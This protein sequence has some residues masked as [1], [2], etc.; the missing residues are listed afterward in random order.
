MTT[1][2]MDED[3]KKAVQSQNEIGWNLS[4]EGLWS[5]EWGL[6]QS[7]Y[8]KQHTKQGKY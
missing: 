6:V 5:T 1:E 2:L 4:F 8:L 7:E 3:I